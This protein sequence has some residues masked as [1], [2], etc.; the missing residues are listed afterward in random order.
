[1][2]LIT[3]VC[4][5]VAACSARKAA[6][7]SGYLKSPLANCLALSSRFATSKLS[8]ASMGDG[9]WRNSC[10]RSLREPP[11]RCRP[12]AIDVFLW[13]D[14]GTGTCPSVLGEA[15]C[16]LLGWR[17]WPFDAGFMGGWDFPS[18]AESPRRFPGGS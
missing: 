2:I 14:T 9:R 18:E 16:L 4:F 10:L 11:D 17:A 5:S 15:R 12:A 13:Q 1:M 7:E 6:R 8:P 3:H